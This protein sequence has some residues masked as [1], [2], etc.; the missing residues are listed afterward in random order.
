MQL[1][2]ARIWLSSSMWV[3][4]LSANVVAIGLAL[5]LPALDESLSDGGLL[6]LDLSSAEQIFGAIAAGMI[7]FTGIVF[8]AVLVAAQIQTGSYSPRLAARLR[9]DRVVILALALPTATAS[10]S[11]FALA[12][13]GHV[14]EHNDVQTAPAITVLTGLLLTFATFAA[15]VALVQRTFDSTQIGGILRGLLQRSLQVV[16]QAHPLRTGARRP[17]A[18]R[19][20]D[21]PARELRHPGA[22][23]VVA[24]VDRTALI[25]L[26]GQTGAFVEVVP[27][28][29]QYMRTGALALRLRNAEGDPDPEL[30]ERVLVLAR[31]RTLDQDPAFGMRIFVDIAIRGLSPAVND[32]TT[33]VQAI[34]RIEA[35]LV[36][37]HGRDLGP[38]VVAGPGG[39][40]VGLIPAPTWEEY[41]D[42]ALI[43]IRHYG[44]GSP[45]IARRLTALHAHLLEI[46]DEADRPR[47][48]LEQALLAESLATA[49]PDPR[50][51]AILSRPDPLGLGAAP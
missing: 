14:A 31:Q 43:E 12:A 38:T 37:L 2:R 25:R 21:G 41:V 32:P 28:V 24:S 36:D 5:A 3:P 46:V 33:A 48:D 22:P 29:G 4:V 9:R 10:Y 51:R 6:K 15:F 45:Q 30:A 49:F 35:M 8:S 1:L 34:D 7:T 13:L 26:A 50:E 16:E 27:V 23:G 47:I 40:P 18:V 42:L 44:A 19:V 17:A 39:D 20:A 11:L